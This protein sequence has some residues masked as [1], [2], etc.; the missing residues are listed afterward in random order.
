MSTTKRTPTATMQSALPRKNNNKKVLIQDL[1]VEFLASKVDD[2]DCVN[3]FFK[4]IDIDGVTKLRP[5]LGLNDDKSF[6]IPVWMSDKGESL[7][8][9]KKKFVPGN[10]YVK[11][12]LYTINI[13]FILYNMVVDGD[14]IKGYYAKIQNIK[15]IESLDN[16]EIKM[17]IN[18][19][20]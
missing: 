20:N 7:L 18:N 2:Y 1:H 11:G 19:E 15:K 8:K 5:L 10:D 12:G 3:C 6:K 13:E 16:I 17:D 9:V 14:T 4:V